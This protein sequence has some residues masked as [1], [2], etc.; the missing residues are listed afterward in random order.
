MIP[1][2]KVSSKHMVKSA[3]SSK[4]CQPKWFIDNVWY[5]ED[6]VGFESFAEVAASRT[7]HLLNTNL[8][9]VDYDLCYLSLPTESKL[10]CCSKSFLQENEVEITAQRKLESL[11]SKPMC[12][13]LSAE[14]K[15]KCLISY[16]SKLADKLSCMFQFD[17]LI[18]NGDRHFHNIVFKNN[19]L[20]LFDN[21]D[22]FTSD[23]TYD[24]PEDATFEDCLK[25]SSA[26]P[27]LRSFDETCKIMSKYSSF[28]LKALAN[29]LQLSDLKEYVPEWFYNRAV[30][31]I[32]HQFKHYLGVELDIT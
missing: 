31:V 10:G 24:Y 19:E 8:F 12:E 11:L 23:I 26:K 32:K 22:G 25:V 16:D 21:G 4:G 30:R 13:C 15:I 6:S 17:R 7:A 18:K 27:F 9:V 3:T 29:S 20:V 2:I 14:D 28:E 1:I 5:K